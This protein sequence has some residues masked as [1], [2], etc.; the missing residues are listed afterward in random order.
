MESL[1]LEY[2]LVQI[3]NFV[4]IA[5]WLATGLIALLRLKRSHL[6]GIEQALWTLII[7]AIPLLGALAYLILHPAQEQP[8]RGA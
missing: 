6:S 4:I 8:R 3:L 1:G 2:L 7:V 5:A